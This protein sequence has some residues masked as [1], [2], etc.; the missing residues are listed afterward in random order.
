M[1][2][3][4]LLLV[5]TVLLTCV[6]IEAA[7]DDGE[8]LRTINVETVFTSIKCLCRCKIKCSSS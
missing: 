8:S 4:Q 5:S 3:M 2:K 7:Q 6:Y 1:V